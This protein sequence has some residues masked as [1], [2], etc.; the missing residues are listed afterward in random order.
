LQDSIEAQDGRQRG[1]ANPCFQW[2]AETLWQ[3]PDDCRRALLSILMEVGVPRCR[4]RN[5]QTMSY[6]R[7]ELPD[8][9]GTR[10]VQK[11]RSESADDGFYVVAMTP[12]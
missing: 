2:P 12:E 10:N 3:G 5:P 9:A 8:V 11:I 1:F 7:S 6:E 4:Q